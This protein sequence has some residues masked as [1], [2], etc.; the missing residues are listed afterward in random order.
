MRREVGAS[1]ERVR[2]AG[3][4]DPGL[5]DEPNGVSI[6]AVNLSGWEMIETRKRLEALSGCPFLIRPEMSARAHAERLEEGLI[7]D[8]G[9]VHLNLGAGVGGAFGRS[10]KQSMR[11][12]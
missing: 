7:E 3:F 5:V 9:W 2:A 1:W 8:S 11:P 4:A 6:K 12:L 10:E